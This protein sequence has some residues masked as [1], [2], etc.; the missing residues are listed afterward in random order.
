MSYDQ[1]SPSG[2]RLLPLVVKNLLIINGL[3]YLAQVTMENVWQIDLTNI[4]GLHYFQSEHFRPYQ[5]VTYMFLHGSFMHVFLNMFALWMFGYLLENFWGPKRFLSFY[6]VPGIG[7]AIVQMAVSYWDISS[8]QAAAAAYT[9]QPSVDGF[10]LFVRKY[11]PVY[12]EHHEMI[13]GLISQW[14]VAPGNPEMAAT[15]VQYIND[16]MRIRM[17]VPTIGA[18]GAVYGI[19]LAFGMMFPNMLIYIYF[20]FP[21]KAK[22]MVLI[23]G[24]IEIF[25]GISNNPSDNVAHFAHLGGMIFGFFMIIYWKKKAR[26]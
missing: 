25:S 10:V 16:L 9:Q 24:A 20:L 14:T 23:Y 21:I 15:S 11:F 5:F 26:Y 3:V 17:D 8:M 6:L 4:L 12:F 18:S 22:W 1:Y 13:R 2:F 7:A 19:L